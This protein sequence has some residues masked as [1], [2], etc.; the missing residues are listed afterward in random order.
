MVIPN[1]KELKTKQECD[2]ASDY[3]QSYKLKNTNHCRFKKG[4]KELYEKQLL[5]S[6]VQ[7]DDF[8][9]EYNQ[10]N[11]K[12]LRRKTI[13][14]GTY[15][16]TFLP[17]F[18]CTTGQSFFN[19]LGK[20]FVNEE[21]ANE[22]W[23]VSEALKKIERG[24]SQKYFSYPR[25]R[26]SIKFNRSDP[27]QKDL[28]AYINKKKVPEPT[29]LPQQVME[30]SGMTLSEYF[31]KYYKNIKIG[32]AEFISIMENLFYAVKRMNDYGFIHQD[33][34][35]NNIVISNKKR[36]RLIDFGLTKNTSDYYDPETN[37]LL[38]TKY[39]NVSPPENALYSTYELLYTDYKE[40][41]EWL[42]PEIRNW[43]KYFENVS[44]ENET[45]QFISEL[46]KIIDEQINYWKE[47]TF[48]KD[49]F[50]SDDDLA[51][52]FDDLLVAFKND[53]FYNF[54]IKY[55]GIGGIGRIIR[56]IHK[57]LSEYFKQKKLA[58]KSDVYSIGMVILNICTKNILMPSANDNPEAVRLFKELVG[59]MI[60][61]NPNNRLDINQ[62]I[63][64][65]KEIKKLPHDDPFVKNKDP[66]EFLEV[67]NS[68]GKARKL[69]LKQINKL[70]KSIKLMR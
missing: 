14:Q 58:M 13:G 69:T 32:R 48:L 43:Y 41:F 28:V 34:K 44:N 61:F 49:A 53:T 10:E 22:E 64:I 17:A 40:V 18:S 54:K 11:Y 35:T 30:F 59:G 57:K 26:C 70:I 38:V 51:D 21:S 42:D 37:F 23:E 29:E 68:F 62:A 63:K 20:V 24:T 3:C 25:F 50:S 8:T 27:S 55:P 46:K 60:A 6:R 9:F 4:I 65:V 36:L 31:S 7:V 47:D 12:P 52:F 33:I 16:I 15:G 66:P 45:N 1:C 67:F 56:S 19:S 39:H 5:P 2:S